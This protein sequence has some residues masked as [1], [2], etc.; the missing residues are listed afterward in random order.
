M[1]DSL[2]IG[3]DLGGTDLKSA[4]VAAD[5]SLE[6]FA[7]RPSRAG[8]SAIAPLEAMVEAV[9]ELTE[10]AGGAALPI[11]VG[12]P[13]A[14]DP[15][16]G[17]LIGRTPHMPHWDGFA[18]RE[19]L[20]ELVGRD[21]VVDNDAHCAALGESIAGAGRGNRVSFM[22]TVGTGVGGGIVSDGRIFRG[23]WGGAGELGHLPIGSGTVPC[24]CGVRGCVEPEMSGSGLAR[25]AGRPAHEV[26]AAAAAGGATAKAQ[27]DHLASQLGRAIACAVDV[28]NPEVVILGGAV[29]NAGEPLF[30]RVR[31]SV[32]RHALASHAQHLKL[33]LASL[34]ERAGVVGAG[35]LALSGDIQQ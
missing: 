3:L 19:R 8:E 27:V 1:N 30:E 21:V 28:I 31:E 16:T 6:H 22:V 23:A 5:G 35:L 2:A 15:K 12:V 7:K 33:A 25:A 11:G 24:N 4:L 9:R 32:M 13:G 20:G 17:S 18:L 10:R 29:F 34:G 26:F 14:I